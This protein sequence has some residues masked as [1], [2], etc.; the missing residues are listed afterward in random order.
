MKSAP[1]KRQRFR[2]PLSKLNWQKNSDGTFDCPPRGC[3]GTPRGRGQRRL[4]DLLDSLNGQTKAARLAQLAETANARDIL[5]ISARACESHDTSNEALASVG[6]DLRKGRSPSQLLPPPE[7][8]T[9]R[10]SGFPGEMLARWGRV[11][12]FR[13]YELQAAV[14]EDPT[15]SPDWDT[16]PL[17]SVTSASLSL[18]PTPVGKTIFVRVR[19]VN[20]KGPSPW[21]NAVAALVL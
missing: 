3:G 12:N 20:C 1:A 16:V 13:F 6:W 9:L 15:A 2:G 14:P 21:S 7:K 10:P 5:K 19:T 11:K 17:R 8:L 18:P 4:A